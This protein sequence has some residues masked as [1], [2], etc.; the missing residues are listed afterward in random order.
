L[1]LRFTLSAV[2]CALIA[3]PLFAQN[4]SGPS[5]VVSL[6]QLSHKPSRQARRLFDKANEELKRRRYRVSVQLFQ[7]AAELD[8][9]YWN[10]FNN[11]GYT[12]LKLDQKE[13]AEQVLERATRID[14]ENSIGYMNLS[15]A[16]LNQRE[17]G[18]AENTART[19]L[20]LNPALAEAKVLLTLA[21][22]GR[23]NWTHEGH[24]LLQE[25]YQSVP[26]SEKLLSEWPADNH[27][28][29]AVMVVVTP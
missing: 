17:Y 7:Q 8:P 1:N 24:R 5:A 21:Q 2:L 20:R 18:V 10:A 9:N 23:G 19:A 27:P 15:L 4:S 28:H 26:G 25:S 13:K 22:V 14:P 12:Y 6:Y 16:A 11:L 3:S 29:P